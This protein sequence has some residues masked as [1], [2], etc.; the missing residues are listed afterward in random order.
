[1]SLTLRIVLILFSLGTASMIFREIRRSA[2]KI[3]DSVFWLLFSLML[4]VFSVFPQFPAFLSRLAGTMAPA[5][6]IYLV[7]IFLLL[8]KMFRMTIK[9]SKLETS[10]R[11]IVQEMALEKNK[12][13]R[14]E[15]GTRS[16]G[17]GLENHGKD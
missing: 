6:F 2:L 4:V 17:E 8:V 12:Q 3:E 16:P 9:M 10:I 14:K 5:N 13:E 15:A 7:V 11:D 1:M